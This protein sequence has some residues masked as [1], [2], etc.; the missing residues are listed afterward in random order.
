MDLSA[1]T[2]AIRTKVG[3]DSGLN[4]TLKF[5]CGSDGVVFVDALTTP[6]TVSN[7]NAEA[8]CTISIS[9]ENLAALLTGQL[10]PMNGFMMGKLKVAGDM[11]IAM[12]LQTVV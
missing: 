8:A 10:N 3:D 2:T 11:G 7:D 5:D 1:C 9:L 6:N 4:A 12:R